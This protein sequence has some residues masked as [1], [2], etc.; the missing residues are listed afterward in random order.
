VG[1][2]AIKANQPF[3]G[4]TNQGQAKKYIFAHS[5]D[6]SARRSFAATA[7]DWLYGDLI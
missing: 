6:F 5:V 1:N 2:N 7:A 3:Y 4:K